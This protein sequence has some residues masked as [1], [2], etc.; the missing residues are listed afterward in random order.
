MANQ[1]NLT[2]V[3]LE[4]SILFPGMTAT[5]A[6]E[7]GE[8]E[9]VLLVPRI[10]GEFASVGTVADVVERMRIPGG[11]TAVVVEGVARGV[12]GA[13]NTDAAGTL[14]VEVT[15]HEDAEPNDEQRPGGRARVP[16]GGRGDPGPPR[17]GRSHQSFPAL[18]HGARPA[19]GHVRLLARRQP[20]R[21]GRPARDSR[22]L[23]AA[24]A[25]ARAAA[26]AARRAA[27][28]G[29][30][31]RRRAAGRRAPAARLLPAQADGVDPQGAGRGRRLRGRRVPAQDR[32]GRHARP[33][34]RAGREGARAARADGRLLG[35]VVDDQDLPGLADRGA[36]VEALRRAAR[37]G[38]RA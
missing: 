9:R 28:A 31:P 25:C 7:T 15:V 8:E 32:G 33:R 22:R 4:D 10:D 38:A 13:A 11:G 21:Q 29:Q 27:G 16:R 12:P 19:G 3:P 20:A 26:R 24:R 23:R 5:V 36:V 1:E 30:D 35:R 6:V 14:R 34:A 17:C 37:P 18:H 2:L